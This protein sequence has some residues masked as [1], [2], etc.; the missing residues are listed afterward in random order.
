MFTEYR[1]AEELAQNLADAGCDEEWIACLLACL[2]DGNKAE[3]LCR[4]EARRVE[5]LDGIHK[6]RAGLAYLD[7]L[8]AGLR[9][10][11]K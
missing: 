9:K 7:E 1:S 5:L 2:M 10:P 11:V 8:L 4:L 3:C 6:E